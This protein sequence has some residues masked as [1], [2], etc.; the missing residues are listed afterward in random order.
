[1]S[2]YIKSQDF[3]F[4]FSPGINIVGRQKNGDIL[5]PDKHISRQHLSIDVLS[6]GTLTLMDLG[7]SNGLFVKGRKVSNA[8][9]RVGESFTIGTVTFLIE[10]TAN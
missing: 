9:L 7:S 6:D 1:M 10:E 3:S 8:I 2:F 5:I 4:P